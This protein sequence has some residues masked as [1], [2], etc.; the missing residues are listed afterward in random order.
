MNS[1]VMRFAVIFR[2]IVALGLGGPSRVR[3]ARSWTAAVKGLW[4]T[5]SAVGEYVN[6]PA[7]E[8]PPT[9]VTVTLT[10]PTGSAGLVTVICVPAKLTVNLLGG[11]PVAP[12][13]TAV[14]PLKPVPAIVTGVPTV[15][16]PDA[17]VIL[18]MVG[19]ATYVN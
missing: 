11:I 17:G 3:S 4:L 19:A 8:V 5:G 6:L 12:K 14:A 13:S 10:V 7:F 9:V 2:W 15:V 18:L 1:D 16:E